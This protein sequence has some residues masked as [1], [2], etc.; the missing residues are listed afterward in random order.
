MFSDIRL[1]PKVKGGPRNCIEYKDSS[2]NT[3]ICCLV[4]CAVMISEPEPSLNSPAVLVAVAAQSVKDSWLENLIDKGSC[5][6]GL[7]S[8]SQPKAIMCLSLS[9]TIICFA[10][11]GAL[12]EPAN[13]LNVTALVLVPLVASQ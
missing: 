13:V 5:T 7:A 1:T 4:S 9:D 6:P 11:V 10:I 12:M 8:V 2:V 3:S